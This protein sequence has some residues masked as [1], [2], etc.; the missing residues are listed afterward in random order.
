MT[1][2][3]LGRSRRSE[4][5][6]VALLLGLAAAGWVLSD[7]RMGDMAAGPGG[8][9]GGV[10]W[11][12]VSWGSMMAAMMLP[13]ITPMVVAYSR[14][15][16]LGGATAAFAAGYLVTWV[17]VG[18][19]AYAVI[20]GIRSLA[21]GVLAWEEAGRYVAATVIAA[22]GLYQ[23]TAGKRTFLRRCRDGRA[24]VREHWRAGRRGALRM[25]VEHGGVCVGCSWAL[26]AALLALGAMNL[27]WMAVVAALI[28]SER[29][30]PS[31]DAAR[32]AGA[33][34]LLALAIAVAVAPG[35]VPGLTVP[36]S[37]MGMQ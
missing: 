8:E 29:L 18:L 5:G 27:I 14:R 19:L 24:F 21:P 4:A 17:V 9:L 15:H 16:T 13:A 23:L 7:A 22:A 20:E 34:V 32:R 28:A 33:L 35:D 26:M 31:S 3:A 10:G 36:G 12:T 2:E 37:Q 1:A 6:V 11:F 25:G 30:L